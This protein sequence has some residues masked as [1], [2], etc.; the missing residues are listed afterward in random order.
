MAKDIIIAID[1]R[2]KKPWHFEEESKA[3]A[4]YKTRIVASEIVTLDAA[5]YSIVGYEDL[6]RVEK[7]AGFIEF[8]GNMTPTEHKERFIN[9]MEKLRKVKHK[10]LI[11]ETNLSTDLMGLSVQQF[12]YGLPCSKAFEWA[13]EL[14][15]EFGIVPIFCGNA[16]VK[17]VRKIFDATLRRYL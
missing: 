17:T 13:I 16:G 6:I 3:K 4:G 10:Y 14:E 12:K 15:Q 5:D 9:E 2:E 1:T 8:I 7:K 11:I